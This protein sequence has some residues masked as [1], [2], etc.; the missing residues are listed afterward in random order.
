MV[1]TKAEDFVEVASNKTK[2][3]T[4]KNSNLKEVYLR[5]YNL[6]NHNERSKYS[7]DL[8]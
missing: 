7:C 8:E 6:L 3:M 2:F 1:G 5:C 4:H